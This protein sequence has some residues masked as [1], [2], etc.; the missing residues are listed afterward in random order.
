MGKYRK[1]FSPDK[2]CV[3]A[4]KID[5][6][7]YAKCNEETKSFE[8]RGL[9]LADL[10][11][12]IKSAEK[13]IIEYGKDISDECEIISVNIRAMKHLNTSF[14]EAQEDYERDHN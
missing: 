3:F 6:G 10:F 5:A 14:S 1:P 12:S 4:I 7:W 11:N 2:Y 8:M 13:A 9:P